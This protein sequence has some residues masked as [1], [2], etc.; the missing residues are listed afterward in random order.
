MICQPYVRTNHTAMAPLKCCP[1]SLSII[2]SLRPSDAYMRQQTN[3]IDSDNGLS[4]G[5]RQA[6]IWTNDDSWSISS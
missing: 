2:N 3:I 6:I 5:R 1:V 4:P